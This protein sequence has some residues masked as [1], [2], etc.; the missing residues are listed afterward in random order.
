M[1]NVKIDYT[2]WRQERRTRVIRPISIRYG[3]SQWHTET[4]WLLSAIDVE[5]NKVK[6]FAMKDI[7]SWSRADE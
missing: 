6:E 3:Q 2:N 1:S 4:Q 7:H 5:D